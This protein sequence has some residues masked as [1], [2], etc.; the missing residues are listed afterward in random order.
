ME[1]RVGIIRAVLQ[2]AL[3]VAVIAAAV[4]GNQT[5]LLVAVL[6]VVGLVM[7]ELEVRRRRRV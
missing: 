7:W 1:N 5:V 4:T 6:V 2:V 3:S